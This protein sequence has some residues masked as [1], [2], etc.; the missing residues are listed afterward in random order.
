[1][2]AQIGGRQNDRPPNDQVSRRAGW[3]TLNQP[4]APILLRHRRARQTAAGLHPRPRRHRAGAAQRQRGHAGR[5]VRGDVFALAIGDWEQP[6]RGAQVPE[7]Q[8]GHEG[9]R[10]RPRT[11]SSSLFRVWQRRLYG[12][13]GSTIT[14]C[15]VNSGWGRC[16]NCSTSRRRRGADRRCAGLVRY[17]V[18]ARGA[19][20]RFPLTWSGT[21]TSH[22]APA[23]AGRRRAARPAAELSPAR[24]AEL[25]A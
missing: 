21:S 11:A 12:C 4:A 17:T 15:A 8:R 18:R 22:G 24:V 3:R 1:M 14:P 13:L 16:W 5:R 10:P 7:R 19:A 6:S 23:G 25:E 20:G 2:L 9:R